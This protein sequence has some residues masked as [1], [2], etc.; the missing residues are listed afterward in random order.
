[1]NFECMCSPKFDCEYKLRGTW[2]F[3]GA[4]HQTVASFLLCVMQT[5]ICF[6]TCVRDQYTMAY[7]DQKIR[8]TNK[9]QVVVEKA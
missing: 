6:V 7:D 5:G 2:H 1:M 3:L 9:Y 8:D 4:I